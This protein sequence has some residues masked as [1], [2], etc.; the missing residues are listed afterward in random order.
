MHEFVSGRLCLDFL[1]TLK[2]RRT[3]RV[4]LLEHPAD[5]SE[6]AI[7]AGVVDGAIAAGR[8]EL[9]ML[10]ALREASYRVLAAVLAPN[11]G[12]PVAGD[13]VLVNRMASNRPVDIRMR[14]DGSIHRSGSAE[15][16]AGTLARDLLDLLGDPSLGRVR[17]CGQGE[18]TRL[19]VD[20]SRGLSRRWCTMAECGNR[21]KVAAFRSRQ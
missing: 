16:L 1:G 9:A 13:R 15:Q 5:L 19:F 11:E 12:P 17:E 4:E 6:W 7:A 8:A 3:D 10:I 18:C 14:P 20:M 2:W 21:S